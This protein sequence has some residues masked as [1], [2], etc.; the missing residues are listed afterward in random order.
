MLL[1][2]DLSTVIEDVV[3]QSSLPTVPLKAHFLP[4]DF[5]SPLPNSCA[6]MAPVSTQGLPG[7]HRKSWGSQLV[8]TISAFSLCV[9]QDSLEEQ[10][11]QKEYT[12]IYGNY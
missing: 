1:A 4:P 9:N 2:L 3:W 5:H 11:R 8:K 12:P 7:W 10:S 6:T